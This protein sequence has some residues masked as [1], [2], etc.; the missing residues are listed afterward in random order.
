MDSRADELRSEIRSALQAE[1]AINQ[2]AQTAKRALSPEEKTTAEGHAARAVDLQ[3]QLDTHLRSEQIKTQIGDLKA[4]A[5]E[6]QRG[7][8]TGDVTADPAITVRDNAPAY[9]KGDALGAIVSARMRF[10]QDQRSAQEWALKAY[11]E[12]SPQSR[13]MQASN[14]TA[15]GALIPDNFVGAE[16]IEVLRATA[17]FR[18]AGART[19]PLI[20]GTATLP[21]ITGG[22]TSYWTAEGAEITASQMTTG[23]VKMTEKKLTSLVPVS[24][25]LLRTPS[26]AVDRLI[27][28]DMIRSSANA[29]DL[30]ILRGDGLAGE[31]KGI[32]YWVGDAGRTN[33]AGAT[34]ANIRTDVRAAK[35]RLGNN[36]APMVRRAWFMHSQA[37]DFVGT[38]IVDAN[39]NLVW[40]SMAD[41]EGAKWNGGIVYPDNN[42]P[43]T[44]GAG[45]YSE[46]YLVEMS[47]CFIGDNGTIEIEVFANATYLAS[48]GSLRSGVSAD[49]SVVRLIRRMDFAMRHTESAHVTEQITWGN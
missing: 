49:E 15:G 13:A 22:S 48:N 40:P 39:S 4:R 19:I 16:V 3:A 42:I 21:K 35:K 2:A 9:E 46:V 7:Q 6:S 34:L 14:F 11:G 27:R 18:K 20:G 26:L 47:E 41:G 44:L 43:L 30:G 33:S 1:L 38:E 17:Q 28:D 24:N 29:E 12:R 36:N 32:Y 31:L 23:S 8:G 45:A 10:G 25:D 37:Q 5:P